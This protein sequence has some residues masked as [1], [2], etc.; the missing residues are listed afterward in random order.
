MS[1]LPLA[2]TVLLL[3][4]GCGLQRLEDRTTAPLLPPTALE[5]VADLEYPPGNVAVSAE[6]RIFF[7]YHPDVS[8][9]V[10]VLE[11]RGGT[12][13]RYPPGNL[14]AFETVL[15]LRIDRQGRLWTLDHG[16]FGWGQPRLTAFDL[17]SDRVVHVFDFPRAVAG[18]PSMLN[19]FQVSPDGR[20]IYIAE[21]SPLWN[22]PALVVYDVERR[23]SRRLLDGHP[24][25]APANYL[26]QAPGREMWIYGLLPLRIGLDSIALDRAGEWLYLGPLSG[27]RLYRVPAA[28]LQDASVPASVLASRLEDWAPKTIS[29]GLTTDDAGRVYLTDP[30]HSAILTIG[31]ERMLT[32]L[33]RDSRLRWPDGLSFGP[34][35]WLYVT[36]SA[37][38][39]VLFRSASARAQHAPYQIYR[40]RPGA[41]AAPGH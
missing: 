37:L 15:S 5:V 20:W 19:D 14:V 31:P 1:T 11:L 33:L 9:P 13:V 32:T 17:A 3:A 21:S 30:E 29:D 22:R 40:F 41:T 35:G 24:A 38:H 4:A 26:L 10:N 7:T 28:L 6:G 27:D 16:R 8:P 2:A 39:Q 36:C 34:D 18:F 12:P 25:L 23:A